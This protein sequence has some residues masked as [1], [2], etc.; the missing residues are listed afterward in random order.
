VSTAAVLGRESLPRLLAGPAPSLDRH[1]A[2]FGR[3]PRLEPETLVDLLLQSG[4]TGRGGGGFPTGAKLA[5]VRARRGRPVVVANGTEGEP[6]SLKDRLLLRTAP[7]LVLDGVALAAA[8]VGAREAYVAVAE[9]SLEERDALR[10]GL[11]ERRRAR[12]GG[13]AVRVEATPDAFVA[14][15]ETALVAWLSGRPAKPTLAPPR[16]HERGVR[17]RPTLVQNVETLAH[18]ALVARFGAPWFRELGTQEEPGSA[19]VTLAGAVHRPG[20]YEIG[21]GTRLRDLLDVAGGATVPLGAFLVGG[22]FGSWVPAREG[23]EARLLDADLARLGASLGAR[24]VVALP[25]SSCGLAETARVAGW[26]AAESAGQCGPCVHGL[27]ALADG[28][29]RLARGDARDLP[30]LRRWCEQVRGRGACRHPDGA[31]RF[32]ASA[33]DVFA[34]EV[35]AHAHGRCTGD[36]RPVLPVPERER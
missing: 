30:R 9:T 27:A 35:E 19:L 31:V 12:V 25:A 24:V 13:P 18:L 34:N 7:H 33:L 10:Q 2:R 14:G 32:L 11:A 28:F 16:P 23:Y 29:E 3:F 20:V 1:A 5:A 8:A 15:E 22:Y 4:L 36:R 21:L 17:G 6:L 26:L